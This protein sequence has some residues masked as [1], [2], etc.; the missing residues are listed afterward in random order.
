MTVVPAHLMSNRTFYG[1]VT[2]ALTL[3]T[4][5]YDENNKRYLLCMQPICDSVRIDEERSFLFAEL[6]IGAGDGQNPASHVIREFDVQGF[7]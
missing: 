1:D 5:V 4:T 6:K 7:S 3:G 2:K